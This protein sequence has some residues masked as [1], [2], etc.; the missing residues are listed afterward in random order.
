VKDSSVVDQSQ[1]T[2]FGVILSR[3]TP[4][5]S[6]AS[7][8]KIA[9][10]YNYK[11]DLA[12]TELPAELCFSKKLNS[13]CSCSS[14]PGS[15]LQEFRNNEASINALIKLYL[16]ILFITLSLWLEF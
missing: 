4:K 13:A 7:D 9:S 2:P 3:L 12:R 5:V 11:F 1:D 16:K 14:M 8:D 6:K 10:K 15:F